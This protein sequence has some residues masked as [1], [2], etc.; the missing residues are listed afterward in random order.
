M[1]ERRGEGKGGVTKAAGG[2]GGRVG[3][4]V[5]LLRPYPAGSRSCA[6]VRAQSGREALD[7]I[8]VAGLILQQAAGKS[9]LHSH[10]EQEEEEEEGNKKGRE[11]RCTG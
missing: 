8:R 2:A 3:V 5:G 7:M 6:W 9:E 10:W 1:V 11:W 4:G